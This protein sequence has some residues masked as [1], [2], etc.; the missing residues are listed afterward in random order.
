MMKALLGAQLILLAERF[1][2]KLGALRDRTEAVEEMHQSIPGMTVRHAGTGVGH[3]PHD[4]LF[5]GRFVAVDW[6]V[7]AGGFPMAIAA[8]F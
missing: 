1:A 7:P 3:N 6:A 8:S 4:L 5:H 2:V